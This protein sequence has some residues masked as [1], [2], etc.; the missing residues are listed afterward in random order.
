MPYICG[1][2]GYLFFHTKS[3]E[4]CM[5][6]VEH[7]GATHNRVDFLRVAFLDNNTVSLTCLSHSDV[8]RSDVQ[9]ETLVAC[10]VHS[11]SSN[12]L[13]FIPPTF[14]SSRHAREMRGYKPNSYSF[15]VFWLGQWFLKNIYSAPKK[16]FGHLHISH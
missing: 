2:P 13:L 10:K 11:S 1:L 3:K 4:D 7:I 16:S 8:C 9:L 6:S 12:D 5:S 14:A 15:A